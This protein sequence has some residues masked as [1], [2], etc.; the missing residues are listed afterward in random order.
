MRIDLLRLI[1]FKGFA[2]QTFAFPRSVDALSGGNG[3]FHVLIGQNG[4]GKTSALDALAVAVGSWLL[5]VRGED[6][7]HIWSEDIRV[8]VIEYGD[9]ARIE[10]QL[11]VSVEAQGR[12][13]GEQ[14]IWRRELRSKRTTSAS[15]RNIK[16]VA[17][18]SIQA[19][20]SGASVTLPLIAYYGTGRLWQEPRD[21]RTPATGDLL[22]DGS[23][24]DVFVDDLSADFASRFSY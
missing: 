23:V 12:V 7:R 18:K 4:R 16:A 17:E 9:T 22:L 14:L 5:G 8:K 3:S 13:Q 19:M 11:P 21:F 1:N 20:Q 24:T 15:A 2:D 10:Q 6:S